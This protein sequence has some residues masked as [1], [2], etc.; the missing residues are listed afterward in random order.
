MN[1]EQKLDE[2][3]GLLEAG[4]VAAARRVA[5][6][7]A[8]AHD[9][10]PETLLLLAACARD[11]GDNGRALGLLAE[12]T[13]ADPEWATPH[14]WAAE[15]LAVDGERLTDALE[16]A[17]LAAECSEDEDEYLEALALKAGLELDLGKIAA[18]RR[19]LGDVP[20]VETAPLEGPIALELA[21]LFLAVGDVDETRRRFQ[22]LVDADA[23]HADAWHGLGLAAAEQGD[24]QG[25]R[26]AWVK[27]LEIDARTPLPAERLSEQEMQ[28]V[29]DAAFDELPE[30]ARRL[31]QNVPI[32]IT[33]LP[34]REDVAKGLDPRLLGLFEGTS[35]PE[36]S[37]LGAAPQLTRI[38]LF[39]KN[40]ERV[41]QDA[42]ELR[43]EIRTTLL[44]ETGH[45]FGMDEEDLEAVGL[46]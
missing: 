30:K 6:K 9:R 13:E 22:A 25:R 12:A 8:T 35:Y 10:P 46:D 20:P 27:V 15:L 19:T 23:A 37:T 29:A 28:E 21:H 14:L 44:H 45:F 32:L 34:A 24:E 42:D 3:W 11:E 40:L 7:L 4:D 17:A 33:D 38:L 31:I 36:S 16:H 41:A 18:A 1:L 5:E 2:A 39:R 26:E 43:D